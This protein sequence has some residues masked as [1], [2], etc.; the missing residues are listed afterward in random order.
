MV[1]VCAVLNVSPLQEYPAAVARVHPIRSWE[2]NR[3]IAKITTRECRDVILGIF[4]DFSNEGE[5]PGKGLRKNK[6]NSRK[7][8][9]PAKMT[10]RDFG[11]VWAI[12]NLSTAPLF[13]RH[14]TNRLGLKGDA[15]RSQ[16]GEGWERTNGREKKNEKKEESFFFLCLLIKTPGW[17]PRL[18]TW[19]SASP[20]KRETWAN[21]A[22]TAPKREENQHPSFGNALLRVGE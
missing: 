20:N 7:M 11:S 8:Y 18:G 6:G 3:L 1:T 13:R 10:A 9:E 12:T 16:L 2:I 14:E 19:K 15:H 17:L 5:P 4:L 21:K 22:I